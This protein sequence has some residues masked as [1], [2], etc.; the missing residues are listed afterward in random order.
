MFIIQCKA[1]EIKNKMI[2]LHNA[3]LVGEE[4]GTL[5]HTIFMPHEHDPHR[6]NEG[7]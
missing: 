6:L 7:L 2:N 4:K 3:E 5:V 1:I